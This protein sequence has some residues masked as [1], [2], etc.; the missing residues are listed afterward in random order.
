[1]GIFDSMSNTINRLISQ[2]IP[3]GMHHW[4]L[5]RQRMEQHLL[6]H[7]QSLGIEAC[8]K[9][10]TEEKTR[11]REGKEKVIVRKLANLQVQIGEISSIEVWRQTRKQGNMSTTFEELSYVVI[12][13]PGIT[14]RH[15]PIFTSATILQPVDENNFEWTGFTWGKL[16]L[17]VERLKTD[18]QLNN[19]LQNLFDINM[20]TELR[21][22]ALYED[23]IEIISNYDSQ[24]LPSHELLDCIDNIA[25]HAIS[26]ITEQNQYRDHQ[27]EITTQKI[28]GTRN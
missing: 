13:K 12:L 17:L 21:I 25:R 11:R 16:P 20:L 23:R 2:L 15:I 19:R 28:F 14:M 27:D 24:R 18:T 22:R 5:T 6:T 10:W 9:T 4:E 3:S 26:Y 7:F 8:L 1:M